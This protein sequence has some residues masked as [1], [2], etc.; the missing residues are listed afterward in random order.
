[1][2]TNNLSIR[3][4]HTMFA[5]LHGELVLHPERDPVAA[6]SDA[7][8]LFVARSSAMGWLASVTENVSGGVWGMND[9]GQQSDRVWFQVS[10]LTPLSAD[11]PLPIQPFLAC[12]A[13]VVARMGTLRLAGLQVLLPVQI[14]AESA[15]TSAQRNAVLTLVQDSGW[16][17]DCHPQHS[18][19]IRVT[20]DGGQNSTICSAAS[21]MFQWMQTIQ[22]DVFA[23]DS[24]SLT[25]DAAVWPAP[26][27][28]QLWLGPAQ[29]RATFHGALV[30]WS[31]DALGWLAAFF[32]SASCQYGVSTPL[33]LT[34]SRADGA[35]SDAD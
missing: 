9:A 16:F 23:C 12:A 32:A 4:D 6:A 28:D 25:D 7:Y 35:D 34:F 22:Q 21:R 14:L 20:V 29:H 24:F 2:S 10:V 27:I 19:R 1:M 5:A 8:S 33:L 31:L 15:N 13:D 18:T 11:Q 17:A 3:S 26:F 30:E